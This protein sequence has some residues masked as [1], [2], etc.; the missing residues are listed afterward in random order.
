VSQLPFPDDRFDLVTAVETHYYWPDLLSDLREIR[1]VIRPGG[2]LLIL[3]ELHKGGGFDTLTKFAMKALRATH[4]TLDEF[5]AL[6]AEAG[7]ENV[8][9][10]SHLVVRFIITVRHRGRRGARRARREE[11]E[12]REYSTDE[13]RREAG[14]IGG[15]MP[16]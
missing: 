15:R 13:Q 16:P 11:G 5:R 2:V 14:C 9:V 10:A 7:Y 6:L 12:Y 4:L 1:R 8:Q 3:A